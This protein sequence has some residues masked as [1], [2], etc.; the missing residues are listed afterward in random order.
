MAFLREDEPPRGVALDV[1]PG[2][3]RVVADNPGRM[4]YHGTN[5][6]LIEDGEGGLSLLDPGPA[7]AAHVAALVE[8]GAGRIRRILLTH[9]HSDHFGATAALKSAVQAPVYAWYESADATFAPD[10]GLRD[11]EAVAGLTAVFTPGHAAD[12]LCFAWGDGILFSGDHVM[13]WSSTIVSPPL[14]DMAAYLDNLARLLQRPD[15]LY[16]C[17]HG[18]VLPDPHPYLR[19]LIAHRRRR[20]AGILLAVSSHPATTADLMTRLYGKA[21]PVL[22][23]AA[24]RNVLAHLLKL[25]DEGKVAQD[26]ALWCGTSALTPSR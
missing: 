11:G 16:L 6:Y 5:S 26:G 20:E 17:G 23:R 21:D 4:T 19:S 9:S 12:H 25:R 2:I 15:R 7:S 22:Q 13:G 14:G 18:P 24:E 8:A 1:L 10:I 3:R